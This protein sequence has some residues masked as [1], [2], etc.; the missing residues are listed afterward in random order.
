MHTKMKTIEI[1]GKNYF[2]HHENSRAACRGIVLGDGRILLSFE[3]LTGQYMIPGGGIEDGESDRACCIRE[4]GEE[5]GCLVSCGDCALTIN[6]Y[7]E[8]RQFVSR[9]FLCEVTGS[10]ER[11]LT[12]REQSVGMEPVWLPVDDAKS[13]FGSHAVYDGVDE[14]RRGLYE[15]EY[16]ALTEL[17]K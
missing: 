10:T 8:D 16:R 4:V 17:L 5:T 9:Y 12:C 6:E 2:G 11:K 7:Y 1:I 3:R 15:R 13:V 14:M